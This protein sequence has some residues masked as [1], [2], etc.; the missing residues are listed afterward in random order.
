MDQ[1]SEFAASLLIGRQ[2]AQD[3][4]SRRKPLWIGHNQ[5][6]INCFCVVT[7][8]ASGTPLEINF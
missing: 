4:E 1:K 2:A 8:C 6:Q 5:S 7:L 3:A